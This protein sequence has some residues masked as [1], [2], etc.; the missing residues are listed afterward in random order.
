[1]PSEEPPDENLCTEEDEQCC[2]L[3]YSTHAMSADG[4]GD[5][6]DP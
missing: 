1:M 5:P 2:L 6:K 4:L 3:S